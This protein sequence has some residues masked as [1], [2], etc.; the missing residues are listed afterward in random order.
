MKTIGRDQ[1][2]GYI[3][4]MTHREHTSL[5]ELQAALRGEP[6]HDGSRHDVLS[7]DA[8]DTL[9]AI[10]LWVRAAFRINDLQRIMNDMKDT[11]NSTVVEAK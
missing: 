8:G 1:Q 5:M 10:D 7:D 6:W 2:D 4:T 11:L 9:K 3:V